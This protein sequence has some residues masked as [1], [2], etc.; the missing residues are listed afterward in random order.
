MNDVLS[1]PGKVQPAGP[2]SA[3]VLSWVQIGDLHLTGPGEQ[4]QL[5]LEAIVRVLNADF[6]GS[7]SFVYLPGDVAERG[8]LPAYRIARRCLD[9]LRVPWC[10]I[11]GAHD[12]HEKSFSNFLG[13][14]SSKKHY[15]FRAG[16][17]LFLALNAFDRPDPGS[18][19]ILADQIEWF[20]RSLQD[21]DL[22]GF[23]K[24]VLLHCYP[25]D[26]K[27]GGQRVSE[28]VGRYRVRLV[29]M[30]HTHYNEIANDGRTIYTATRSTGQIEEGPPG[31]SV[32][33]LDGGVL[34]WRFLELGS[35]PAAMIT[36]PGDARLLTP[37]GA[38]LETN[39]PLRIRAKLW[40]MRDVRQVQAV[41]QG[42]RV[43]LQPV[44]GSQVWQAEL[45]VEKRQEGV[46]PLYVR[47]E[48]GEGKTAEDAIQ[49]DIGNGGI[50]ESRRFSRD[51]DN[52]LP[53]WPEHGLLATQLGPNKN[54][55]KW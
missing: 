21:A 45:N 1:S 2:D 23:V 54:G 43:Q 14:M 8:D 46:S 55:R 11:L 34:S 36:S 5:D 24:A 17:V 19:A 7:I 50:P 38:P 9:R 28:L 51:Q 6:A 16:G 22:H 37:S 49:V 12:V 35:L 20:E 52:C 39:A 3:G 41:F 4:N 47:A 40:G 26:L 15:R 32:V 27:E 13:S 53:A 18:F 42:R 30:G 48:D 31:F 10:A 44:K 29:A 25:S 33:N